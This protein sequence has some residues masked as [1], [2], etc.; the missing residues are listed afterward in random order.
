MQWFTPEVSEGILNSLLNAGWLT[1][2]G[3]SLTPAVDVAEIDVPLGWRPIARRLKSI[4]S[5]DLQTAGPDARPGASDATVARSDNKSTDDPPVH[6]DE[7]GS[8]ARPDA[9][10]RPEPAIEVEN[11]GE[12]GDQTVITEDVTAIAVPQD[13]QQGGT[14]SIPADP[15][16]DRIPH[17]LRS[18]AAASGLDKREVIRRAQRKRSALGPV[19]LWMSLLLVAREQRIDLEPLLA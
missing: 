12:S 5:I 11:R 10:I 2:V 8:E 18:I 7:E 4:G 13:H 15:W 3:E 1:S 16:V 19:T 17:L 14:E 9:V 6:P